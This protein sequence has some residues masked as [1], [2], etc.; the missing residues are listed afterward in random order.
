MAVPSTFA[1]ISTTPGSNS[2]LISDASAVN[3]VDDHFRSV[4]AFIASVYANSGNGWVSPYLASASPTYT[5]ALTGGA[6]VVNIGSGQ[7][8]KDGSGNIGIGTA[9]PAQRLHLSGA[10]TTLRVDGTGGTA[11]RLELSSA[12]AVSWSIR[13]NAYAGSE[14][15]IGPDALPQ[16]IT[17]GSNG[18]LS[19][20]TSANVTGRRLIV[21]GGAFR[22]DSAAQIEFGG[23]TV[24]L[25]GVAASNALV[26]FTDT[27]ERV[28]ID[29]TGVA[30][31][32][33]ASAPATPTGGGVLYVEA[34][35][36]KYIGS[37]GT[38]TTLAAA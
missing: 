6:G 13:A 35:A 3:V 9:S 14:L 21:A 26:M 27:A 29:G 24:G 1:D 22:L 12:G 19:I 5:G 23:S 28:R 15:S 16:A 20:G 18:N 8:Y 34:G 33:V 4:Y 31:K 17:V 2:G 38:I 25:Y 30:I 7:F 10:T 37:S 32:D 36:L 11:S